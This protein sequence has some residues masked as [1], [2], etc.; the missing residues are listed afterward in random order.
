MSEE[1]A[2][3]LIQYFRG[4][5]DYLAWHNGTHFEPKLLKRPL[6]AEFVNRVHLGGTNCLGFYV[7][8]TDNKVAASCVDFDNKA[9]DPD[10]QWQLKTEQ[11]YYWLNKCGLDPLVERS[12][13]GTGSHVWLF[14]EPRVDAW[15][16]RAFWV[17]VGKQMGVDFKEIYPRQSAL[18]GKG[19]GNLVRLP[20]WNNSAFIDIE[21]EWAE[22]DAL[23]ALEDVR[24][25]DPADLS[26]LAF[27]LGLGPLKPEA[28]TGAPASG[29]P[30]RIMQLVANEFSLVGKRWRGDTDGLTDT[31][32]SA[33]AQSLCCEFVRLYVP[34]VEIE[35][36]LRHWC[37][38]RGYDKG[39]RDSWVS[40][41]VAKAYEY[42]TK[43]VEAKSSTSVSM[44]D[45]AYAF[46][47]KLTQS[48]PLWHRSGIAALDISID[49]IGPG[50]VCVVAARPGHGKSAV[51]FQWV[52]QVAR[53][54]VPALVIS[55]E[56][57]HEE[58]G[59]RRIQ[60][61]S[62]LPD[63]HWRTEIDGLKQAVDEWYASRAP[64]HVVES[65]N[66]IDRCEEV[67]RQ[68]AGI[69]GVKFVVIDYLQL[70]TARGTRY[71]AVTEMSRRIKQLARQ[72]GVGLMLLSQLSRSV[73]QEGREPKLSDLRES[74]QIEQD[75]DMVIFLQW[76][77]KCGP[78]PKGVDKDVWQKTY[79]IICAKRR[80]GPIRRDRLELTFDPERQIVK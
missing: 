63:V 2:G 44:K 16:I 22:M 32:N 8:D 38:E 75:A 17:A 29:L 79:K 48:K 41:T 52:D 60:T 73:E 36:A 57:S 11:L 54:G 64:V 13:S 72:T 20:L 7:L 42:V 78:P 15:L 5:Q 6:D 80:N 58:I 46:I 67:V 65:C 74:G 33:L 28:A 14:F 47:D 18:K 56:M 21:H 25:L 35:S 9:T 37:Q 77:R 45:S 70:L 62:H 51:A 23:D 53:D 19:L 43:R 27:Q 10:P 50:E 66:S 12:Q 40:A 59:K 24:T 4:R 71:E 61:I 31:S 1:V 34:T 39:D 69:H 68:F 55:E 76:C 49:G 26:L 3:K 30:V